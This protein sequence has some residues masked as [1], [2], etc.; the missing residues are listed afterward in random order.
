MKHFNL[1]IKTPIVADGLVLYCD[2]SSK[3]NPGFIGA[4]I[5]GY[6]YNNETPKKGTGL[7][8][9]S[10]TALGYSDN[11]EVAKEKA[12]TVTPVLY[13]NCYSSFGFQ[14]TNNAAEL[15]AAHIAIRIALANDVKSLRIKTDSEYTIKVLTK[16]AAMWVKS[17]WVKRDGTPVSNQEFI[18]DILVSIAEM[19]ERGI[20][21]DI[22]WVR[23]H[24]DNFGNEIA[25]KLAK[26]G[27]ETSKQ[28]KVEVNLQEQVPEGF[29]K[30]DNKRHPFLHHRRGYF[31]STDKD[32]REGLYLVGDHGKEDDFVGRAE[33]DGA[34]A[35]VLLAKKEEALDIVID[36]C[37]KLSPAV[38][39]FFFARLDAI[40]SKNRAKDILTYEESSIA[41]KEDAERLNVVSADS[42]ELVRDLLPFR[43]SERTFQNLAVL[44]EMLFSFKEGIAIPR[45][46]VTD[47]T[48]VFYETTRK[49]VKNVDTATQELRKKFVVGYRSE[50][51]M[52]KYEKGEREIILTLGIDIPDRNALKR[53]DEMQ[54]KME[55]I[56]WMESDQ[57]FRYATVIT[58]KEGDIGIWCGFHSNQI[59]IE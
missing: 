38:T 41:V 23:G 33:V 34:L 27:T 20:K 47:I 18:K 1:E 3:P 49:I 6:A 50:K 42:A 35:V 21:F 45:S 58:T 46:V 8:T 39:R 54:A 53:L 12:K 32:V 24:N 55:V 29:W 14:S 13:Y 11:K 9:Q 59:Y 4:G 25:D 5:H 56:T 22:V 44:R 15:L 51:V 37:R 31:S 36:Y 19:Q 57:C 17:N 30:E 16:F 26:I 2:G 52:V 28:R 7:S 10:L 48:D 40:Y 43:L